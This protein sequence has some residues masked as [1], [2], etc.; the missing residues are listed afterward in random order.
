MTLEI[1]SRYLASKLGRMIP[2]LSLVYK[3]NKPLP[4]LLF[5]PL[6]PGPRGVGRVP[7][8]AAAAK[9]M[10]PHYHLSQGD[11]RFH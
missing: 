11:V 5:S 2:L 8:A 3:S 6:Q 1:Q 10:K 9:Q 7:A 4:W